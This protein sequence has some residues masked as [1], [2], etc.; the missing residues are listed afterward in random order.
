MLERGFTKTE[1][2][3]RA[4]RPLVQPL[5]V[6]LRPLRDFVICRVVTLVLLVH[7]IAAQTIVQNPSALVSFRDGVA[8]Q[9]QGALEQAADA[10]ACADAGRDGKVAITMN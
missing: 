8:A 7:T 2:T 10:Y 6:P 3:R 9:Q 4:R 1:E 5:F